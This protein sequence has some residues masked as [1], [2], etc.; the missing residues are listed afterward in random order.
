MVYQSTR[1]TPSLV[2][3]GAMAIDFVFS[4]EMACST[5]NRSRVY[6]AVEV[7]VRML[8]ISDRLVLVIAISLSLF[9]LE[10]VLGNSKAD[11]GNQYENMLTERW[12]RA[13]DGRVL[14]LRPHR[15]HPR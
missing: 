7:L 13:R 3:V 5:L 6:A 1:I 11:N 10:S 9:D 2:F 15:P 14:D 12:L 4:A 8:R